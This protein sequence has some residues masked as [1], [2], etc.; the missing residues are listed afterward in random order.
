MHPLSRRL[1]AH[2]NCV[3][4]VSVAWAA[5]AQAEAP[6]AAPAVEVEEVDAQVAA[7]EAPPAEAWTL[8]VDPLTMLLGISQVL[9]ERRLHDQLS[10]YAGPSLRLFDSPLTKDSEEGYRAYGV[11]VGVRWFFVGNAPG[12]WW[13]GLR[14]VLARM[15]FEGQAEPGGY[16]S[17]LLG[18]TWILRHRWV[19]AAALGVSYFAYDV[20]GV[21]VRGFRPGAHTAFGIAF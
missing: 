4:L 20:G 16:V 19:L 2:V 6:A 17:A 7:A 13:F 14:G 5:S 3:L 15:S 10:I 21:G 8:Q 11:E 12:S 1:A 18:G 9:L